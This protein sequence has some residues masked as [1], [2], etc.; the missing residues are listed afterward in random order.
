ML[1]DHLREIDDRRSEIPT[2]SLQNTQGQGWGTRDLNTSSTFL[3]ANRCAQLFYDFLR[4]FHC[5]GVLVYV[6]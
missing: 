2:L 4:G 1:G 6:E 3:L 5:C